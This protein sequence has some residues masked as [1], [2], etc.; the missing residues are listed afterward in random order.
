M[1]NDTIHFGTTVKTIA[2][3]RDVMDITEDFLCYTYANLY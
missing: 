1:L 2:S 3:V